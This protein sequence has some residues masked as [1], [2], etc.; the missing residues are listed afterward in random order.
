MKL[1]E[2]DNT[3]L[4]QVLLDSKVYTCGLLRVICNIEDD[5]WHISISHPSRYPT[6][7][8]IKDIRY[9]L[10]PN[11]IYMAILLPPVEQYVNIHPNCFHLWEIKIEAV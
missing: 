4:P 11:D 9:Q 1:V 7:D 3:M 10:A 6:W 5:C 8:E 2:I